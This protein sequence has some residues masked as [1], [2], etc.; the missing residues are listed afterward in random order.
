MKNPVKTIR[1]KEVYAK[2]DK[3]DMLAMQKFFAKTG[4]MPGE[5]LLDPTIDLFD[6]S[7][8]AKAWNEYERVT[9]RTKDY[10]WVDHVIG[11]GGGYET[12]VMRHVS[13]GP[14]RKREGD[15]QFGGLRLSS[16]SVSR[17][18]IYAVATG[19]RIARTK[20]T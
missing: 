19:F 11:L 12:G 18:K 17:Q 14:G 20:T 16:T 13:F 9:A 5:V 3:R 6:Q 2:Q 7:E 15:K 1:K 10:E 8:M 4:R